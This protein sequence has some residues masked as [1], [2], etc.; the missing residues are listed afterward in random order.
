[1]PT[2]GLRGRDGSMVECL[3]DSK[4]GTTCLIQE[5]GRTSP[6]RERL[7]VDGREYVPFSPEN[8]L[9]THRVVLLPSAVGEHGDTAQLLSQIRAFLHR[10]VD[11]PE[12]FEVVAAHYI[13][14]TWVYDSFNELPY[15]RVRGQYG[16]GKSRF[17]L[18]V[19]SLCYKP[20][21][22]SGAS[23]I[24]PIFRL[25]DQVRGTLVIDEADFW[26]SDERSEI[27]KILNNGNARGFPVLRNDITPQKEFNPRAFDIFGP[28]IVAT[29]HP[30]QD[31]AL[32][33]RC[34]TGILGGRPVRPDIP[35]SLPN[36]FNEDAERLRNQLLAF[37]FEWAAG[38]GPIDLTD[39]RG[40]SHR[41][42]QILA[43]LLA[44]ATDSEARESLHSFVLGG[45]PM[46]GVR[47]AEHR[48][49]ST[50]HD[51]LSRG[52][53]LSLSAVAHEFTVQWRERYGTDVSHRWIGA[54]LRRMGLRPRKSNGVYII[55]N[56]D[57]PLL[58]TLFAEHGLGDNGDS[59]DISPASKDNPALDGG[60]GF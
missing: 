15:L 9:L 29:R 44:V 52:T 40:L 51:L 12:N 18:T 58:Q 32:E 21:F 50:V 26:A 30:F 20:I 37:R 13:L 47:D 1:M 16:S 34:L 6:P 33:S 60:R 4:A 14:L 25:L 35:I 2:L 3:F 56:S 38:E 36:S 48:V 53:A 19:G 57:L 54:T 46:N 11:L 45:T 17:L 41:R 39:S 10:Y 49:L 42:A 23:T 22:A 27:V 5:S 59:R 8:N 28:K 43:P 31:E 24:S 7:E 55:D